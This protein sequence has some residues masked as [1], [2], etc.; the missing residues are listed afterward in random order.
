LNGSALPPLFLERLK[1]VT[2]N[3][4]DA[5]LK[6]MDEP[7]QVSIRINALKKIS[8]FDSLPVVTW[9]EN[10]YYLPERISFTMDPLFHA[11]C[12]YVQEASS[13]FVEK[14]IRQVSVPGKPLKVLD[15]CAAPGGKSTNLLSVLP[16]GSLL[17][18]NEVISS[19]NNTLRYNLEKWGY[20]NVVVTQNDPA[21]FSALTGFFDIIL[22][23]APCSGEGLFRKDPEAVKEW[24]P[25]N[26][27]NCSRRQ[28]EILDAVYPALRKEGFLI[29]CTWTFEA[30]ENEDQVVRMEHQH[31]MIPLFITNADDG[32]LQSGTGCRFFPH[33]IKGEG[34]FISAIKKTEAEHPGSGRV[35]QQ[36]QHTDQSFLGKFLENSEDYQL[37]RKNEELYAFPKT[38]MQ[39]IFM[40]MDRFFVRKA[41]IHLGTLKGSDLVPSHELALSTSLSKSIQRL[42]LSDTDAIRYLRCESVSSADLIN[43]WAV[44][45]YRG[46]ALGWIKVIGSR[47]NNYFPKNQRIL[48]L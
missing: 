19:R 25:D 40:L 44:V 6:S 35:K 33:R 34:F 48:K 42:E 15:L 5:F 10:A 24:S 43:G 18:S 22:V 9:A 41:G 13:M 32:I 11:G 31:D 1:A 28:S 47:V 39:D 21:E 14:V 26:V 4:Y 17:V 29:Y 45:T 46:F 12:Y 3:E 23:D 8:D 37:I 38:L 30:S 36:L 27:I 16:E 2:G 7:A 20:D